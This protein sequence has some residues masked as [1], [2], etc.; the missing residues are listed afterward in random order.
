MVQVA[1]KLRLLQGLAL[2]A[3]ILGFY[4]PVAEFFLGEN[5]FNPGQPIFHW[6]FLLEFVEDTWNLKVIWFTFYQAFLSALLSLLVGLPGAWLISHFDFPGKRLFQI[7]TYL[8]F[9]L[10][11]ILVVLGMVLFLGNNGLIN[12]LWMWSFDLKEPPF[13]FLYSLQGILIAHVFYNFPIAIKTIGDQWERLSVKYTMAARS[14]GA[15]PSK[16][17]FRVYLPLLLPSVLSSFILIFIL[18][19]NSFAI[20]LVL[21]G[22]LKFTTIEVLIYQLARIELDFQGAASLAFLQVILGI[23]FLFSLF[24]GANRSISQELR[25]KKKLLVEMGR[26]SVGAWLGCVYLL[27][28]LFFALGP[29]VSIFFDSLQRYEGGE[30]HF[31][32]HW[33]RE[34]FSLSEDNSFLRSLGN[35]LK[36]GLGSACLSSFLGIGMAALIHQ[37]KNGWRKVWEITALFPLALSTVVFGVAWY[38]LYQNYFGGGVNLTLV[39]MIMHALLTFPYWVRVVLPALDVVP[40]QWQMA[41]LSLGQSRSTYFW[42]ILM[43]WLKKSLIIGFFFSFSLSL[44]ELNSTMMIADD[45]VRTLPLEI[46]GAISGYRFS[47][48]SA[49]G[50]I[51]LLLSVTTFVVIQEI[52]ADRE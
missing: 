29:L 34:M 41:A 28:I 26:G 6:R 1:W 40:E 12:R 20:I 5:P 2:L 52:F 15:S 48:A 21:G 49:V 30:W 43:P 17:F 50:V 10:P 13:Q 27:V 45:S 23:G 39:I 33:Y 35:S 24:R 19:L 47:Y 8:P 46:Y 7:L 44:G 11:S 16:L 32:L 42:K 36:I 14:L 3:L 4:W 51:L 38:S 22:G 37:S 18:C 25:A 31:T 9:I